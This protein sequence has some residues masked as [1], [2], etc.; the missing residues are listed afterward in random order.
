MSLLVGRIR[1]AVR[2]P[3]GSART[4]ALLREARSALRD[5]FAG[6]AS[7]TDGE[8]VVRIRRMRVQ[9][10]APLGALSG[11]ALARAI[12]DAC[13]EAAATRSPAASATG[14]RAEAIVAASHGAD[15]VRCATRWEAAAAWLV[16]LDSD[17]ALSRSIPSPYDDLAQ[18]P[19]AAAF[20]AVLR[21]T[22]N[23]NAV[24]DALGERWTR[25]FAGRCTPAEARAVLDTID[26][27][28]H[29]T[30]GSIA[31]ARMLLAQQPPGL[32]RDVRT[33]LT[34][35][36]M[37]AAG[38]ADAVRAARTA[39]TAAASRLTGA[40]L[41]LPFLRQYVARWSEDERRAIATAL[42]ERIAGPSA[43]DDPAIHALFGEMSIRD[44]RARLPADARLDRILV[45]TVRDFARTLRGFERARMTYVLQRIL[46]G[47]AAVH[48]AGDMLH[49]TLPHAP[50]RIVLERA[51]PFGPIAAP[52]QSPKLALVRDDA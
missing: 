10:S 41:L 42:A 33:A 18:L 28:G 22:G 30:A 51:A 34:A 19:S 32:A 3:A 43:A 27:D 5:A 36:A 21:R 48:A 12:A 39:A 45:S 16:A 8:G 46:A 9:V 20:L 31:H 7:A 44:M 38:Y 4:G 35:L 49:A 29:A 40:W 23:P 37:R 52:W 1:L 11:D 14:N 17:D 2:T 47:D 15:G 6:A 25:A 13:I 50:L 24:L 26:D